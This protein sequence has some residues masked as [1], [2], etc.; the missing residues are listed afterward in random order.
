MGFCEKLN[1]RDNILTCIYFFF[2]GCSYLEYYN[3]IINLADIL[4]ENFFENG[5]A[6]MSTFPM[7][8]NTFNF[9][10]TVVLTILA[11]KLKVYPFNIFAHS[12]FIL[13][14]LLYIIT[15][16]ILVFVKGTFG[17]VLAVIIITLSGL[18][19]P[20]NSSVFMGLSGLFSG[21]HNAMFF[22]GMAAGG[23]ISWVLRAI[24]NEICGDNVN[25][26]LF[27]TFFL[28]GLI[29]VMSHVMY[30]VMYYTV[31][32]TRELYTLSNSKINTETEVLVPVESVQIKDSE[33]SHGN[34][35][36]A[37]GEDKD[38]LIGE[39]SAILDDKQMTGSKNIDFKN[40][41]PVTSTI[42]KLMI[43]L[44]SIGLVFFV[45]LSTFPG[46][47][48]GAHYKETETLSQK[49]SVRVLNMIFMFGDLLSRF[50]VYIPIKFN[51]WVVFGFVVAR[52]LFY[53]PVFVYY[54]GYYTPVPMFFIMLF[55]SFTNGYFSAV[56]IQLA[57]DYM[58]P[59]EKKVGGNLVMLSMNIG[60][61]LGSL[62]L[63]VFGKTINP[64]SLDS[65][66]DV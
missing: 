36:N 35:E 59:P 44:L 45:T 25:H 21:V 56:A 29:V 51:Q 8:Y 42:K 30:I 26:D 24:S 40:K 60:L 66:L 20:M 1:K 34:A 38:K 32:L 57:N 23:V 17:F 31:P 62:L 39:D 9:C 55:F 63:F 14:L 10:I 65:S 43:N 48:T 7:A 49:L 64:Y 61:T 54:L 41:I 16:F 13:H 3:T 58:A 53:I 18:P 50:A 46:L 22:I 33:D 11:S 52:F 5:Q 28:N 4:D 12:A 27:L 2:F 37:F 15:P 47:F 6:L 19:T